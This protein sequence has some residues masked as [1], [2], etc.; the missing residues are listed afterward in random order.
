MDQ[1][2]KFLKRKHQRT[3]PVPI[4]SSGRLQPLKTDTVLVQLADANLEER[5]PIVLYCTRVVQL[6]VTSGYKPRRTRASVRG[7]PRP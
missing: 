2:T 4:V 1:R 6:A 5:E 3:V 7:G